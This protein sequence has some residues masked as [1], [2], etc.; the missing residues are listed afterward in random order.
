VPPDVL[1][2]ELVATFFASLVF[3]VKV[4]GESFIGMKLVLAFSFAA[5]SMAGVWAM[6]EM[7]SDMRQPAIGPIEGLSTGRSV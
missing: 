3:G 6:I 1:A 2:T 7:G 4:C 5:L